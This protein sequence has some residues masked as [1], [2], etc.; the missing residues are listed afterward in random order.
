M[1][2]L[3]QHCFASPWLGWWTP[4]NTNHFTLN[5]FSADNPYFHRSY[6][7][8]EELRSMASA[9]W[10][11]TVAYNITSKKGTGNKMSRLN[12]WCIPHYKIKINKD[13][14]PISNS[15]RIFLSSNKKKTH[16][17]YEPVDGIFTSTLSLVEGVF[18]LC[19]LHFPIWTPGHCLSWFWA[20][21]TQKAYY[22][23]QE[24][25]LALPIFGI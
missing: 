21:M 8:F 3:K 10:I 25:V 16:L 22:L 11:S 23:R 12:K 15:K 4:K 17:D 1:P 14:L 7:L 6:L 20:T 13:I 24:D 19:F 5:I 9:S 18:S 2:A